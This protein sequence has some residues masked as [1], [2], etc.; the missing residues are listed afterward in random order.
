M[1]QVDIHRDKDGRIVK[2]IVEGH[3]HYAGSSGLA[4]KIL[5]K[6]AGGGDIVC[7]AVS[8]IAQAAVIGIREVAGVAAG[9]EIND[10]YLE[11]IIPEDINEEQRQKA[12]T[13]LETM[14]LALK[15]IGEQYKDHVKVCETEV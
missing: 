1:V 7:A 10:G 12:N 4:K 13:V 8:A 5:K 15:D 2:Y 3:A 9:I 11:C 6:A 14:A